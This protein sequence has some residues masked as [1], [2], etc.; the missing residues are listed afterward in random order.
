MIVLI[1]IYFHKFA[2]DT[3]RVYI[4]M[5]AGFDD[6]GAKFVL[7]LESK[8]DEFVIKKTTI[9]FEISIQTLLSLLIKNIIL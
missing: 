6:I 2:L 3:F 4:I 9:V 7:T 1:M 5:M 8:E